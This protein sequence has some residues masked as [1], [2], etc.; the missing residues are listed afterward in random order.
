MNLPEL[1]S[2]AAPIAGQVITWLVVGWFSF[3][4]S[5]GAEAM[6]KAANRLPVLEQRLTDQSR[7]L[8]RL[9]ALDAKLSKVSESVAAIAAA[10]KA[11]P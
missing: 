5:G 7:R 9:E 10:M 4:S 1:D 2:K 8:D 11:R 6:A 3:Q